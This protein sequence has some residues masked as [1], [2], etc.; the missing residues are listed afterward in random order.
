MLNFVIVS[1]TNRV[2]VPTTNIDNVHDIHE[3]FEILNPSPSADEVY[4]SEEETMFASLDNG[5]SR[6]E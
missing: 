4:V 5:S 3:E 1:L 2:S 6:S